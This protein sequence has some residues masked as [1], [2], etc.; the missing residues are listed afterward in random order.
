MLRD[1]QTLMVSKEVKPKDRQ[2]G[3]IHICKS[4]SSRKAQFFVDT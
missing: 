2:N 4:L 1:L 3:G